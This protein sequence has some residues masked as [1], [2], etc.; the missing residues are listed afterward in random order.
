MRKVVTAW[1]DPQDAERLDDA[2]RAAERFRS[3]ELRVAIRE[4]LA[5]GSGTRKDVTYGFERRAWTMAGTPSA[6]TGATGLRPHYH[7]GYYAAFVIDPDRNNV[8]A[9]LDRQLP[10]A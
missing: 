2:A 10:V 1:I 4:H 5:R 8:E 3:A 9:V 7:A 6:T